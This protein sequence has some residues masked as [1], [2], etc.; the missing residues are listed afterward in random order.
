L[1][2][3]ATLYN[4]KG[5]VSKTTTTFNLA[6]ALADSGKR[7]LVVDADP[8]CN[9]T[10][11]LLSPVIDALD[12]AS[13]DQDMD[14]PLPG[15]SLLDILKPRIEGET[16]EVDINAVEDIKITD[17]I[18]LIRGDVSLSSIEDA[19]AE[20]HIQRFS[21]KIH[22]RRTYVAFYD[23][24]SRYAAKNNF[25]FVLIDVGPSSGAIT[26]TAFLSCDMFIVPTVPDRF[27]IQAIGTLATILDRWM[28]EHEQV[29]R[30]FKSLKLNVPLGKPKYIGAI[31][32]SFTLYKG[33]A[34]R[35][36][37]YWMKRIPKQINDRLIPVLQRHSTPSRD[38][39]SGLSPDHVV[40]A[41]IPH[42]QSLAP[43]MQEAGK[44]V[45]NIT[46]D[47][48]KRIN[49]GAPYAGTVWTQTADRIQSYKEQ[50]DTIRKAVEKA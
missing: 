44:A 31:I 8:Q 2:K 45:F 39:T 47:D 41:R 40:V 32:Q 13:T 17:N 29:Y 36:F 12:Q 19:I 33:E 9:I 5:G 25:D 27:N 49:D 11:L 21:N 1:A 37:A 15:T 3:I 28:T 18:F 35:S 14:I 10:E 42:F 30:D 26:R 46:A 23:F 6:H 22:E 50:F 24:V 43:I 7:V 20:A 16:P 48:T 34:K 4:H 38:L